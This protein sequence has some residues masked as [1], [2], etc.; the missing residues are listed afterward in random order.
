MGGFGA[1]TRSRLDRQTQRRPTSQPSGGGFEEQ[2]DVAIGAASAT[3]GTEPSA[4][5]AQERFSR[6]TGPQAESVDPG[7]R[8]TATQT[9]AHDVPGSRFDG[10]PEESSGAH[11]REGC[12]ETGQQRRG[13]DKDASSQAAD[14]A[15]TNT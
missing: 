14:G 9:P 5:G 8:P 10:E 6:S 12:A 15:D 2:Q 13:H 7:G 4:E 3:S 11:H 1:I